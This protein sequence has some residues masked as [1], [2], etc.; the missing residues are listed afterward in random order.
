MSIPGAVGTGI[1]ASDKAGQPA[2]EVYLKKMT[3]EA[4]AAAPKEVDG[5]P[6]K[7][8]ENGGFVAY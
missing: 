5:L 2:I 1:G 4:K 3:P 6:V 8:I 7:L